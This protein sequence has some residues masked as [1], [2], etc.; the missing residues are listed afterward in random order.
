MLRHNTTR[1]NTT[2]HYTTPLHYTTLHNTT[3]HNIKIDYTTVHYILV[4][5]LTQ[6]LFPLH[7]RFISKPVWD[8]RLTVRAASIILPTLY[9]KAMNIILRWRSRAIQWNNTVPLFYL[10]T[11]NH[12]FLSARLSNQTEEYIFIIQPNKPTTNMLILFCTSQALLHVS[13][14]LHHL[15]GVLVLYFAKVTKYCLRFV[16]SYNKTS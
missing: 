4:D 9:F 14:H 2:L 8:L 6:L 16:I 12:Y 10:I 5:S 11:T 15:Q 7:A 3:Q 1:H 13:M